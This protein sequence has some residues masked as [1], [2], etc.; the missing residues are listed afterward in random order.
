MSSA[1]SD[2]ATARKTP[3]PTLI[4]GR[5]NVPSPSTLSTGRCSTQGLAFSVGNT[6]HP[7]TMAIMAA[8]TSNEV[9]MSLAAQGL[10][11]TRR[12]R[13]LRAEL[14]SVESPLE[15]P[16][17]SARW[18]VLRNEILGGAG[19]A[20]VVSPAIDHR[21]R[22][23]EVAVLRRGVR[24]LP[25]ERGGAPGIAACGLAVEIAPDQ[26][27]QEHDLHGTYDQRCDGD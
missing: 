23:A 15:A 12:P 1:N 7:T 2:V 22:R 3:R 5:G 11:R 16:G 4:G 13:L 18:L 8:N 19:N 17:P 20:V 26:V 9:V 25:L 24:G 10:R 27:V 21:Q 14:G 6:S